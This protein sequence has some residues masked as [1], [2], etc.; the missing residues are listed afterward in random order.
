VIICWLKVASPKHNTRGTPMSFKVTSINFDFSDD[1]FE[2]PPMMQEKIVANC[3]QQIW[4][5]DEED[6]VD[7]ISD[8]YGFCVLDLDYETM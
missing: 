3:K 1:N 2:L 8:T 4:D 5:I 7:E 6:L